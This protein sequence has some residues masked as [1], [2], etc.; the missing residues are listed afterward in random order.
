M[1]STLEETEFKTKSTIT[2]ADSPRQT[3]NLLPSDSHI[4]PAQNQMPTIPPQQLRGRSPLSRTFLLLKKFYR[5][6]FF[7]THQFNRATYRLLPQIILLIPFYIGDRLRNY[8][9]GYVCK[10]DCAYAK[11]RRLPPQKSGL[12]PSGSVSLHFTDTVQSPDR[13]PLSNCSASVPFRD[14]NPA[15]TGWPPEIGRR[16]RKVDSDGK[17]TAARPR[18]FSPDSGYT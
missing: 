13:C 11:N 1:N 4:H 5:K 7:V 9:F 14:P 15:P 10:R 2:R 18:Q 3:L 6:A 12:T 17:N 16:L 8:H